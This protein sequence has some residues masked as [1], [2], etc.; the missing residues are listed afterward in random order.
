M[1]E[2]MP[3]VAR[4]RQKASD[5]DLAPHIRSAAA[6]ELKQCVMDAQKVIIKT[7]PVVVT[8]CIGAHQLLEDDGTDM[9]F[10]M[11]VL[12]E[13]AQTTEPA[14]ICALA[15]SKAEQIVLVGDTRQLPPTV[16]SMDLRDSLGVSPMARLEKAG[17]GEITLR[18]QY[19]MPPGLLQ[20]PSNYFYNGLVI[21]AEKKATQELNPPTGFP[22]ASS[23][24]LAFVQIG[25]GDSE[26][27]HSFGGRSNLSEAQLVATIVSLTGSGRCG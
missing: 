11:V 13:A 16:T 9:K 17:V 10:P 23:Q 19:R 20:H 21:C 5:M 1:S 15:A 26:V 8:S 22:W 6:F 4:L 3:Q 2:K 14:L 25:N 12:D 27:Q 7:A 24:P 18:V